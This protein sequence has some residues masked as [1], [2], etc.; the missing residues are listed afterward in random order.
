[1]DQRVHLDRLLC[2]VSFALLLGFDSEGV[3]IQNI[4]KTDKRCSIFFH[5][6]DVFVLFGFY[7]V[8]N[9]KY[10]HRKSLIYRYE[11]DFSFSS[12]VNYSNILISSLDIVVPFLFRTQ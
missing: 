2:T 10:S 4:I 5:C 8:Y 7:Q 6:M 12:K 1:M 9:R 3:E 11:V